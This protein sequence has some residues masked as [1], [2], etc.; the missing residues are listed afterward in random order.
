MVSRERYSQ[1]I[2]ET[3]H[4]VRVCQQNRRALCRSRCATSTDPMLELF[5]QSARTARRLAI[6]QLQLFIEH[7]VKRCLDS[8]QVACAQAPVKSLDPFLTHHIPHA[9]QRVSILSS[10]LVQL[11]P[12]FDKP[13]GACRSGCGYPS[14]DSSLCME[15]YGFVPV[16]RLLPKAL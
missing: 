14:G 16:P 9:V 2:A 6:Q 1:N 10:V 13:N 12:R 7:Q 11:Q 8:L 3:I 4:F 5:V 15:K